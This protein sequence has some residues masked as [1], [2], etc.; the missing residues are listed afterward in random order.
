MNH[1]SLWRAIDKFAH[2]LNLSCSGL[3]KKSGLDPTTFNKSKRWT[4][5]GKPRWPSTQSIAK[6]L[7]STGKSLDDF[8]KFLSPDEPEPRNNQ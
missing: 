7:D 6:I 1:V 4:A 5:C 2:S 3:A 8:L